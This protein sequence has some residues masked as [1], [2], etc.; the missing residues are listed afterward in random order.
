MERLHPMMKYGN[1]IE[2]YNNNN[3]LSTQ[4]EKANNLDL[5]G[6][7]KMSQVQLLKLKL[8]EILYIITADNSPAPMAEWSKA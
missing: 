3:I 2:V 1:F 4:P 7:I 6:A 8:K 5:K